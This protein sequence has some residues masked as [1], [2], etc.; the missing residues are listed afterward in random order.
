MADT[1]NLTKFLGDVADAIRTKKE[2]NEPIPAENFDQEIL[3][4]S[5]GVDTSDADATADD[6]AKNRTA[7]VDGQKVVGTIPDGGGSMDVMVPLDGISIGTQRGWDCVS[8]TYTND[9]KKIIRD[10]WYVNQHMT[11]DNLANKLNVTP[12]KIVKG[13]TILGVEGTAEGGS[14]TEIKNQDKTI[15]E[16]GTYTADEGYTGLGEVVVNVQAEGIKQFSTVDDMQKDETAEYGDRAIVYGTAI[17]NA[18]KTSELSTVQCPQTVVLPSAV[19]SNAYCYY[20]DSNRYYRYR[21]TLTASAFSVMD[22]YEYETVIRYTSTDATTY[23]RAEGFPET[24]TF[25]SPVKYYNGTWLDAI[26][27]FLQTQSPNFDG[28]FEYT[29]NS[30]QDLM[31]TILLSDV[32]FDTSS[33]TVSWNGEYNGPLFDLDKIIEIKNKIADNLPATLSNG[34]DAK[35]YS[36]FVLD[37]SGDPY[38]CMIIDKA[39]AFIYNNQSGI[40]PLIN[41]DGSITSSSWGNL[42]VD[43]Y[44]IWAYK[45]NLDDM[46]YSEPVIY[47]PVGTDSKCVWGFVPSTVSVQLDY[48]YNSKYYGYYLPYIRVAYTYTSTSNTTYSLSF[49]GSLYPDGYTMVKTQLTLENPNELLPGVIALGKNKTVKGDGSIYQNLNWNT[50]LSDIFNLTPSGEYKQYST[51]TNYYGLLPTKF[52]TNLSS[53]DKMHF[54]KIKPITE[55]PAYYIGE[56]TFDDIDPIPTLI[57]QKASAYYY[58]KWHNAIISFQYN[59]D[60]TSSTYDRHIVV[61]DATTHETL[62]DFTHNSEGYVGMTENAFYT[63]YTVNN[64]TDGVKHYVYAYNLSTLT[65]TTVMSKS[66]SYNSAY[67]YTTEHRT[68]GNRYLTCYSSYQT[69]DYGTAYYYGYVYDDVLNKTITLTNGASVSIG[70]TNYPAMSAYNTKDTLYVLCSLGYFGDRAMLYKINK[71]T[72]SASTLWDVQDK[73]TD[74][75]SNISDGYDIDENYILWGEYVV[76]KKSATDFGQCHYFVYDTE[77]NALDNIFGSY[78][79]GIFMMNDK[80]YIVLQDTIYE[81]STITVTDKGQVDVVVLNSYDLPHS[82]ALKYYDSA[83][84]ITSLTPTFDYSTI[85]MHNTGYSIDF[86]SDIKNGNINFLTIDE[87]VSTDYDCSIINC[88]TDIFV[89]KPCNTFNEDYTGTISPIEYATA[90]ETASEI[91]GEEV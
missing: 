89:M 59:Y 33:K 3:S 35:K 22:E 47:E 88:N 44:R 79:Y 43:S 86:Y 7:Y 63:Y 8:A 70:Y 52:I 24:Y 31:K 69:K 18:V 49:T 38:I 11:F 34:N 28:L 68:I 6:I 73:G 51:V 36:Y 62:A 1:S 80:K 23:T 85:N 75:T 46:T 10:G 20:Y 60:E 76:G 82:P 17:G 83:N 90:V 56:V 21:I 77:G 78:Q 9:G 48:T 87:S 81:F 58:N 54:A 42:T 91:S 74:E 2:T 32:S 40:Y 39:V 41:S 45:I 72:F 30:R 29:A 71:S 84:A 14:G 57:H 26:G 19:T 15:T 27:Y 55:K 4:I 16:N 37:K 61:E 64:S 13:E 67:G 53:K 66:Y 12:E 65:K 25:P 5:T 50:I